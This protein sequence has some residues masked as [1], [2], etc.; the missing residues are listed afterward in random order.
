VTRSQGEA[1][2]VPWAQLKARVQRTILQVAQRP[3]KEFP[4]EFFDV[5]NTRSL[6]VCVRVGVW[7]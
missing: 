1:R 2:D 5:Q 6:C 4:V 3:A 7:E